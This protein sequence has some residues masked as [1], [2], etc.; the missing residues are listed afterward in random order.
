VM[1]AAAIS[2][3]QGQLPNMSSEQLV[4][5]LWCLGRLR[6]ATPAFLEVRHGQI[7]CLFAGC[8][9][10]CW[11]RWLAFTQAAA[12][13]V[14]YSATV[15][16]PCSS[17]PAAVGAVSSCSSANLSGCALMPAQLTGC[18]AA[19]LHW[20]R[21]GVVR[22]AAGTAHHAGPIPTPQVHAQLC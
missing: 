14:V 17:Y 15:P 3:V 4:E 13:S 21:V 22:A 9:M 7:F 1:V 6:V 16:L 11:W 2:S 10:L 5:V 12:D 20:V 18:A 19:P 8:T